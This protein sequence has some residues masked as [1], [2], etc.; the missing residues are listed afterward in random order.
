M[1]RLTSNQNLRNFI[2]GIAGLLIVAIVAVVG[3]GIFRV[4][5]QGATD[6]FSRTVASALHL[7]IAKINGETIL[8]S[9]YA[10]DLEAINLKSAYDKSHN[11]PTANL[12]NVEKSDQ[13]LWRLSNNALIEA[14]A[15]KYNVTASP[16]EIKEI[17]EKILTKFNGDAAAADT[18]LSAEFGWNLATY[19][20]KVVVPYILGSKIIAIL[21]TEPTTRN[22]SRALA[23][24]ILDQLKK[25]AD[26]ADLAARYGEDGSAEDGGDLGWFGRGVMVPQF[27]T[28]AF[29][30][31]K[32]EL[33]PELVETT[34]GFHIIKVEDTRVNNEKDPKTNKPVGQ[35]IKGRHILIR[36]ASLTRF[37][38]EQTRT[39]DL[40]LYVNI[41]NPFKEPPTTTPAPQS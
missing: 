27:E 4:Y 13:V 3:T 37:L 19:E 32:G 23:Q 15:K 34:Y 11:G 25:G 38:N 31:K 35:E 36:F 12:S 10:H 22:E 17:R 24:S 20:Q 33:S 30:L 16:E 26:F 7:P 39:A 41:H 6:R 14:S 8:Y 9:D 18:Q 40:H 2:Y 29:K 5:R 28:P 21:E 1:P